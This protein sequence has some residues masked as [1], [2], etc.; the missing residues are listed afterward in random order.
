MPRS[1]AL[2]I[3][4]Y[5]VRYFGH[6]LK[7]IAST[8]GAEHRIA[9]ALAELDPAPD[10]VCLQ[11]I[12]T[13]SLRSRVARGRKAQGETQLES[14]LASIEREFAARKRP[15]PYDGFYFGAHANR[16]RRV[17]ITTHGLAILV[18]T[19][20]LSVETHNV[21]SPHP[22]THHHVKRFRDRK[23]ARICAHIQV[24]DPSGKRLHVFNTHISLPTPFARGFWT[25]GA[26]MG[27]G[28]NQLHEARTLAAFVKR[29][30]AGDPFVVCGDFNSA[31]GSPV[32][33]YLTGEAG[34]RSAQQDLGQ[35]D[36]DDARAWP[37][38]GFMR[39][40]MHLDHLFHGDG[41]RFLDLDGSARFGDRESPFAGLSDHVPLVGRL[42]CEAPRGAT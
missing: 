40:R 4:T 37:T 41:V 39:M 25:K 3:V 8:R 16:I 17:N 19:D 27:W 32:F 28:V 9:R 26:R 23:Q 30:S 34:F 7:G 36:P 6:A 5:N 15:L 18:N 21:D 22:I 38:A 14:F 42:R 29:H 31:P 10:L 24:R 1:Q 20:R 13:I 12:E 33:Q 35:L 2:R 11:E